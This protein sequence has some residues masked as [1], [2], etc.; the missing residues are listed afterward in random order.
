[1][2][3]GLGTEGKKLWRE[4]VNTFNVIEEPHNRRILFDACKTADLIDR[5]D[6]A[7]NGQELTARGSMGQ[8]VIH[9]LIAQAQSA[10]TLLAQ[11]L[12]RLN[13]APPEED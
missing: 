2:P 5:L 12:T 4:V 10:R 3:T 11:L 8:L 9:P 7:M 1:M 13:F 6:E